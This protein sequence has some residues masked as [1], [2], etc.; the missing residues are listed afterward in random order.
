VLILA[1]SLI[2]SVLAFNCPKDENKII[3]EVIQLE[4]SGAHITNKSKCLD[5]KKFKY[6]KV[7]H[8]PSEEAP[9]IANIFLKNL[10]SLKMGKKENLETGGKR[11]HFTI[12]DL[13]GETIKDYIDILMY[14]DKSAQK[15]MGCGNILGGSDKVI[16]F[17]SCR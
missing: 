15:L 6:V 2:S 7:I 5:Q 4:Y 16:Q 10:N 17:Q 3:K 9:V 11:I 8:S 12:V 14:K 13:N 1:F